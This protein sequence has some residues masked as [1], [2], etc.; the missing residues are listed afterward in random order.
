MINKAFPWKIPERRG[1]GSLLFLF[2]FLTISWYYDYHKILNYKPQSIHKWRQSDCA[3][4]TL[5]YYQHGMKFFH[6]EVHN[7]ASDNRTTGYAVGECPILYYFIASL[8][9]VFGHHD[10]IYRLVNTLLFFLGLFALY[11]ILERWLDDSFWGISLALL[12]FSSPVVVYY[13]NNYLTDT[14]SFA[15][16]L[17]G[18]Y[19]FFSFYTTR[20]F[21]L[22]YVSFLFF[23]L[24]GLLKITSAIN[25]F[26]LLGLY[27]IYLFG[28]LREKGNGNRLPLNFKTL[29]PFAFFFIVV[30]AW[31]LFAL[32]YNRIH[33]TEYFSTQIWPLWNLSRETRQWI[34]GQIQQYWLMDYFYKGTLIFFC[35]V[36]LYFGIAHRR[37][38]PVLMVLS[39]FLFV[40][41]VLF[42][43]LWY[44]AFGNHDYYIIGLLV[45]PIFLLLAF[46][47]SL[48]QNHPRIMK[49]WITKGLFSLFI[50]YNIHYAA[51]RLEWRY[52]GWIND[53]PVYKDLYEVT[54]HLRSVGIN[55]EDKVISLP[56]PTPCYSLYLMNQRGWTERYEYNRDSLGII[57]S[58]SYGAQYLILTGNEVKQR[59]YLQYFMKNK[60][61]QFNT[62]SIYSLE[63]S[64]SIGKKD[65]L[66]EKQ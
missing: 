11:K 9:K 29:L 41:A 7:L 20:K 62:I 32:H 39:L 18:W 10:L 27:V 25:V 44:Y 65:L 48:H 58:I 24:A 28:W 30:F 60:I 8:Y 57:E 46:T 6:P 59:P 51:Q 14:T 13:A 12:F 64:K 34:I 49:S 56:D 31:Y 23:T 19:F 17:M 54:P 36:L 50:L 52:H 3:S 16:V 2:L 21:R 53:Y 22:L 38:H 37:I 1:L 5:N 26:A 45:I 63:N 4:I 40:E 15:F 61:G 47:D 66:N 42:T 33:Q 35:L 55:P 43:L